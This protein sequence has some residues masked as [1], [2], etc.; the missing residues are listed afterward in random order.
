MGQLTLWCKMSIFEGPVMEYGPAVGVD[1]VRLRLGCSVDHGQ[2]PHYWNVCWS[3][4]QYH[5]LMGQ[6]TL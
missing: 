3:E 4:L 5:H 2:G 1:L 6:L